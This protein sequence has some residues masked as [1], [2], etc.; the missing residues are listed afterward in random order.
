MLEPEICPPA[1]FFHNKVSQ[2]SF[3]GKRE[4]F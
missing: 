2:G 1:S 4:S 3:F